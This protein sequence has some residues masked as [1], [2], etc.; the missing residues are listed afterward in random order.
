MTSRCYSCVKRGRCKNPSKFKNSPMCGMNSPHKQLKE[1]K[2]T[3][4]VIKV[5]IQQLEESGIELN[6]NVAK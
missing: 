3:L 4:F 5:M 2:K 6:K 1:L